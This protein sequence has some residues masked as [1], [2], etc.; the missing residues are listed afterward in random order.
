MPDSRSQYFETWDD[1]CYDGAD[2]FYRALAIASRSVVSGQVLDLGCG[3]RVRYDAA[4]ATVWVGVDLSHREL[5]TIRFLAGQPRAAFVVQGSAESPPF[6]PE[7]FDTICCIFLLH[8]LSRHNATASR[9]VITSAL[10]QSRRLL[11]PGGR[12][13]I[14]ETWPRFLMHAYHAAYPILYPLMRRWRGIELPRF[15]T[16]PHIEQM[17]RDAGFSAVEI[18]P[19]HVFE[20]SRAPVLRI[21]VPAWA[22]R[23]LHSFAIYTLRA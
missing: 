11:R 13:L 6:H 8:H 5:S 21:T 15:F 23:L 2:Q 12:M 18:Q 9:A 22:Q 10:A 1:A 4:G 19:V 14:A 3:S 16:P 7:S 20:A 17:A